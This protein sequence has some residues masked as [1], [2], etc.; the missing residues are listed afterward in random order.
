MAQLPVIVSKRSKLDLDVKRS[1][2]KSAYGE[3]GYFLT[4]VL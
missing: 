4:V 3:I 2:L 1:T